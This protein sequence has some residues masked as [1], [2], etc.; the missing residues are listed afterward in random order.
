MTAD[1]LAKA[2]Q[3]LIKANPVAMN[4]VQVDAAMEARKALAAHE[5]KKQEPELIDLVKELQASLID[6]T[7]LIDELQQDQAGW[8]SVPIEP[9]AAMEIAGALAHQRSRC[10]DFIGPINDAWAA[11]IAAAPKQGYKP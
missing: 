7:A 4:S 3:R 9:T 5:T 10:H 2:L 11:M 6:A 1:K 8:V